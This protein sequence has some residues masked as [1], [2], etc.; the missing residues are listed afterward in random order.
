MVDAD[1]SKCD[2]NNGGCSP[3]AYCTDNKGNVSCVC[4]EGSV[5]D[6]FNCSGTYSIY[7]TI[8]S[9]VHA[10]YSIKSLSQWVVMPQC[11]TSTTSDSSKVLL[12]SLCQIITTYR[13]EPTY[14]VSWK[15]HIETKSSTWLRMVLLNRQH[16]CTSVFKS[17]K[18]CGMTFWIGWPEYYK[19]Y[20]RKFK[21]PKTN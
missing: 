1:V 6:G 12:P 13:L 19:K 10:P 17:S 21:A 4:I 7:V 5:G 9:E 18:N 11:V 15:M 8:A 3:H 20:R 2:V 16:K 14:S